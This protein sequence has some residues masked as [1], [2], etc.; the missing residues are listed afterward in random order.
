MPS[1]ADWAE[2]APVEAATALLPTPF[3][4]ARRRGPGRRRRKH[5]RGAAPLA[6]SAAG[7]RR[8]WGRVGDLSHGCCPARSLLGYPARAHLDLE[9]SRL[10]TG[11]DG[12]GRRVG[13][14]E[15]GEKI[16][17]IQSDGN[18]EPGEVRPGERER[19]GWGSG[20]RVAEGL[21]T[22]TTS[23]RGRDCLPREACQW[24]RAEAWPR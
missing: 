22:C 24:G 17:S 7:G 9:V 15:G 11:R 6:V 13:I 18:E 19:C 4:R 21:V 14:W 1:A 8:G 12:S 10:G 2:P 3:V 16:N 20:G 5:G 23:C